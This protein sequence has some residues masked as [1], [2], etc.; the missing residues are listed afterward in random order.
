MSGHIAP[1]INEILPILE[2]PFA[3][4]FLDDAVAAVQDQGQAAY[5]ISKKYVL[6]LVEQHATTW[7]KKGGRIVSVS[8]GLIMTPMGEKESE[9][10][11]LC[12]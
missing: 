5:P 4:T 10:E 2:D 3:S 8:P 11:E 12:V 1:I 7:G 9:S 6:D